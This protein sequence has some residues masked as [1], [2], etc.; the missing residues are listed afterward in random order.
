MI[1]NV[2]L[3]YY[4]VFLAHAVSRITPTYYFRGLS[5]VL[6]QLVILLW[7]GF[8]FAEICEWIEIKS[9][10]SSLHLRAKG[11]VVTPSRTN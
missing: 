7:R 10:K 5:T 8:I 2:E 3:Q 1:T 6:I 4:T 9:W 11:G